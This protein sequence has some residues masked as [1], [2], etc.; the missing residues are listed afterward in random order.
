MRQGSREIRSTGVVNVRY[1]GAVHDMRVG[2]GR[3]DCV[4]GGF[5]VCDTTE[6]VIRIPIGL[7][8]VSRRRG[9]RSTVQY[10]TR[11]KQRVIAH[12]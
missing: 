1:F 12:G 7:P 11:F 10:A 4:G 3:E 9:C 5:C 2:V 8:E 6:N